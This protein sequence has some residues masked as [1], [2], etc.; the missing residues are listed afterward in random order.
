MGDGTIVLVHGFGS[1]SRAWAP[2]LAALR[3][4]Y[5]VVAPDLPGHGDT[6]GPFTLSRAVETVLAATDG[7][8]ARL[9]GISGGAT[10]ALLACL[11]R[12]TA[13]SGLVLSAGVARPPR[14][15]PINRAM[16][17]VASPRA[18]VRS[19]GELYSGGR[20]E[21]L[22]TAA[23][24]LLRCGKPTLLATLREIARLDVRD[25]LAEI[26]VPTL[27]VCGEDDRPNLA[28]SRELAAGIRGAELQIIPGAGHLWNLQHPALFTETIIRATLAKPIS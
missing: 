12:P 10:V 27:V 3:D 19:L 18:L 13:A 15:L 21:Y 4:R 2:Q 23:E 5:R 20:P 26:A 6:P 22:A 9:V 11:D 1:S 17:R 28:T 16:I 7:R 8:P 25:R 24:D 14:M